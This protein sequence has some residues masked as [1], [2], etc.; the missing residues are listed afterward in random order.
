MV[1]RVLA[2]IS[3]LRPRL[4]APRRRFRPPLPAHCPPLTTH[5]LFPVF[6]RSTPLLPITSLQPR[7][8]H[9]ITHSFAQ[10]RAA[11]PPIFNGFRTLSIA[12]GVY[13]PTFPSGPRR[14]SALVPRWQIPCSQKLAASL[15]SLCA[16]F[17]LPSFVFNRLQPLFPK[18]QGWG[19]HQHFRTELRFPV[20]CATWRLYPLR[21][22]SIAHTSRHHGGVC[23]PTLPISFLVLDILRSPDYSLSTT[24]FR[25]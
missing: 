9:A 14:L 11:I 8:F 12:T 19:Y 13:P 22:H 24:H 15:S 25:G 1:A 4:P 7:Q 18:H 2:Q 3:N 6:E 5:S 21:P 23:T 20:I 10:R 16:L 17:A